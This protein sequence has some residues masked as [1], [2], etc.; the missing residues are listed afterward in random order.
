V[1]I[2][3]TR[4][5]Q[6][7]QGLKQWGILPRR[8]CGID[9]LDPELTA[10][11]REVLAELATDTTYDQIALALGVS[12]NTVRTHV[13]AVYDKLAVSSRTAAVLQG[14]SRGLIKV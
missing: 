12:I 3:R 14:V 2:P 9:E 13:R 8:R 4:D 6:G 10:R 7:R 11:E 1:I 5:G